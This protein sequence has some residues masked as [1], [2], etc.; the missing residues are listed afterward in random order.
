MQPRPTTGN[1]RT[2]IDCFVLVGA[3]GKCLN[4]PAYSQT[5]DQN[6]VAQHE[7]LIV[8]LD[9]MSPGPDGEQQ[10]ERQ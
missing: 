7:R 8:A 6:R 10:A 2:A 5:L 3:P 9:P 4:Y 1:G